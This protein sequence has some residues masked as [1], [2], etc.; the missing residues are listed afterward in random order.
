[1]TKKKV[2]IFVLLAI[3]INS[4]MG[5]LFIAVLF[6]SDY[7]RAHMVKTDSKG[8]QCYSE[9]FSD[10]QVIAD[11]KIIAHLMITLG[12]ER[13]PPRYNA[14]VPWGKLTPQDNK[15]GLYEAVS[16]VYF[17]NI[18]NEPISITLKTIGTV[19]G[20]QSLGNEI[21]TIQPKKHYKSKPVVELGS[22]YATEYSFTL[23][24]TYNSKDYQLSSIAT[25]TLLKDVGNNTVEKI[26]DIKMNLA[27]QQSKA[28]KKAGDDVLP[29]QI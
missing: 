22:N 28:E 29:P 21:V 20:I 4:I 7:S 6:R 16:E 3:F 23:Q 18:S 14:L 12:K 15:D 19:G 1:M 10:M 2:L 24:Y 11:N 27:K 26:Q 13:L 25:R 17:T 9:Y 8:T 5:I